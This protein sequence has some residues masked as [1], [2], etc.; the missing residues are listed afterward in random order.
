M[1][2]SWAIGDGTVISGA[3]NTATF[4]A[5]FPVG[6][7]HITLT[8]TNSGS[9]KTAV[10]YIPIRVFDADQPP[11][12]ARLDSRNYTH[13][14]GWT[15]TFSLPAGSESDLDNLPDGALIVNFEQEIYDADT[16]GSYG[17]NI[18]GSSHIKFVGYLVRESIRIDPDT[19]EVVFEAESP[20]AILEKTPA[21]P[22]LMTTKTSPVKWSQVKSLTVNRALWYLWYWHA[23]VAAYFDFHWHSGTDL[24]YKELSVN[25]I[26]N[27]AGQLRDIAD[28][29]NLKFTCD[30]LGRLLF[31]RDP[32]YLDEADRASCTTAYQLTTADIMELDMAREHRRRVKLVEGRAF[33][34]AGKGLYSR[35]PG[36]APAPDAV[37]SEL[38]DRQIVSNQA[39]LNLRTGRHYAKL[40][41]T[42]YDSASKSSRH[43]P[44]GVT[45]TLPDSYDVFDPAYLDYIT[46]T[47]AD[48]TNARGLAIASTERWLI[49]SMSVDYDPDEG[50]KSIRLTLNHE[51]QGLAGVTYIRPRRARS[52]SRRSRPLISTFRPSIGRP[53][54]P[55]PCPARRA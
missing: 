45:L 16:I 46:L 29:L 11:L 40:N 4:S 9:S 2:Y 7:R 54:P 30:R 32:D 15:M 53:C 8:V 43:V 36:N 5:T 35:A 17:S 38:L 20:L 21:L 34:S 22:Q 3:T 28:A 47:L 55:L 25:N 18:A 33:T 13:Q 42:Y 48:T 26:D 50:T 24:A 19:D 41:G 27:L 6:F 14:T 12:R 51:T 44:Q 37:G 23:S 49:E 31:I 39:E 10:K 52:R 1:S